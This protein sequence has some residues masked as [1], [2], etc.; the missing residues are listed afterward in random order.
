VYFIPKLKSNLIS[1]DQ[2][3]EIGHRVLMDD[4]YIEV[5][6][7]NPFRLIMKVQRT[8]NRLYKVELVTVAPTCLLSS[9]ANEAWLWHGQLGH[10]N[11]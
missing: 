1:L 10:V 9:I 8:S 4:D 7:K 6:E 11:F 5:S 3:T 2:L